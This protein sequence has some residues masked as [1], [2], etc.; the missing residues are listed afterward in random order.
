MN[1][2]GHIRTGVNSYV[3]SG[4]CRRPFRIHFGNGGRVWAVDGGNHAAASARVKVIGGL[5]AC[6]IRL[7]GNR[8]LPIAILG[9]VTGN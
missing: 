6:R 8:C 7:S 3:G 2:G 1:T 4:N 5:V 9:T